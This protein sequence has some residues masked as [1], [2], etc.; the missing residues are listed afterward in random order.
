VINPDWLGALVEYAQDPEIGAV[1]ARLLHAD[2]SIQHVGAVL[3][4][5]DS[6]AHIYHQA[7]REFVGYNGFTHIVRNYS[8]VT[9]ACLATRKSVLAHAG[10]FDESFAV[11]FNDIDLCL[12]IRQAGYRIVYTPYSELYHFEGRSIVR[13]T[14]NEDERQRFCQR[15]SDVLARDPFYNVNLSRNR[16]DFARAE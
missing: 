1:G 8:A 7:P 4:V 15:W 12:K 5:N 2:G 13:S 9:G 14:Q 6:V 3:G 11:D 10:G 16:L